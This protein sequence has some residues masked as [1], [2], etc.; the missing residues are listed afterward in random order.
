MAEPSTKLA[1][2]KLATK[3]AEP[4]T[5]L[6]NLITPILKKPLFA[7]K[8]K[9]STPPLTPTT[10]P[11]LPPGWISITPTKLKPVQPQSNSTQ[12]DGRWADYLTYLHKKRTQEYIN[13]W[14]YDEWER[15]FRFPNYDYD[16]FD[17]LDEKYERELQKQEETNDTYYDMYYEDDVEYDFVKNSH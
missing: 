12:V 13:A 15:M 8:I 10:Q 11:T 16:Y 9:E 14:G 17:K 4:S 2:S 7:D 3:M 6:S 1:T 5:E